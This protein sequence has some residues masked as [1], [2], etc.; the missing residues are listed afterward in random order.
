MPL[1]LL[2]PCYCIT[3]LI[4]I[5]IPIR[6]IIVVCLLFLQGHF[7]RVAVVVVNKVWQVKMFTTVLIII[8]MYECN[9]NFYCLEYFLN[10]GCAPVVRHVYM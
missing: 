1:V 10:R 4:S 8:A 6:Q 7:R 3:I 2:V 5:T 9:D